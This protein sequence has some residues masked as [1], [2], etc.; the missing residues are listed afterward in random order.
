MQSCYVDRELQAEPVQQLILELFADVRC[1][2]QV[3]VIKHEL[4]VHMSHTVRA[5]QHGTITREVM[6][7]YAIPPDLDMKTFKSELTPRGILT[8]TAKKLA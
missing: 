8:I 1:F 7:A 6:R 5:D 4:V 3:K 2:A